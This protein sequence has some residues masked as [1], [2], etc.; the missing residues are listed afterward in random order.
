M[1]HPKR[2]RRLLAAC[3]ASAS[4]SVAL[5]AAGDRTTVRGCLHGLVLTTQDDSGTNLPTPH[6]FR[7]TGDRRT[8]RELKKH[9][10]HVEEVTG[11]LKAAPADAGYLVKEKRIDK[12]RVYM[13]VGSAPVHE[14]SPVP[15][16]SIEVGRFTHVKDRC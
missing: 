1:S 7:L 12:G 6:K 3:A 15:D 14:S 16:A 13:G 5:A 10:G 11:V 9:S 2:A 8:L 4:L